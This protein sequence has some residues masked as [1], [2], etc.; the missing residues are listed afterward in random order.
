MNFDVLE[1][2]FV[3]SGKNVPRFGLSNQD[4]GTLMGQFL[5][6]WAAREKWAAA[7][8][9]IVVSRNPV[10]GADVTDRMTKCADAAASKL[11]GVKVDYL[12]VGADAQTAQIAR[13]NW[14]T[15]HPNNHKILACGFADN[16]AQGFAN[17]FESARRVNDG[18]VVGTGG[19]EQARQMIKAGTAFRGTVNQRYNTYG[20]YLIPLAQDILAGKPVPA[21]IHQK[22][23]MMHT[24]NL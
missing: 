23:E 17:A 11:S 1:P 4:A 6:D 3:T 16:F 14:L 20:L 9:S 13:T 18:V 7:D 2:G 10:Y 8:T 19:S 21:V 5:S 22:L 15:A 12:D 24:G